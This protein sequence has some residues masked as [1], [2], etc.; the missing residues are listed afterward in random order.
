MECS[1]A[2]SSG[3]EGKQQR[4]NVS[5]PPSVDKSL[6]RW[7]H[8]INIDVINQSCT[9]EENEGL[10]IAPSPVALM[11]SQA[12]LQP[13]FSANRQLANS[14]HTANQLSGNPVSSPSQNLTSL[15]HRASPMLLVRESANQGIACRSPLTTGQQQLAVRQQPTVLLQT[16]FASRHTPP[17]SSNSNLHLASSDTA[18]SNGEQDEFLIYSCADIEAALPDGQTPDVAS[19]AATADR[20]HAGGNAAA[21]VSNTDSGVTKETVSSDGSGFVDKENIGCGVQNTNSDSG[22]QTSSVDAAEVCD[23]I[24]RLFFEDYV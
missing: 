22:S 8:V 4:S 3:D 17:Q 11:F 5:S 16:F 21:D 14:P 2:S 9:A 19:N 13:P 24:H 18:S 6:P 12:P 15:V 7:Q 1:D 20:C 23:E 10:S